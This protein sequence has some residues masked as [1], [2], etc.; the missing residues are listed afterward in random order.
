LT[1]QDLAER[2]ATSQSAISAIESGEVDPSFERLQKLLYLTGH[3]LS[4]ELRPLPVL[5]DG[6]LLAD[7]WRMF[8]EE[9]ISASIE[10]SRYTQSVRS[11]GQRALD[12]QFD[13]EL[14]ELEQL[15]GL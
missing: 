11:A 2:A 12:E 3:E 15:A 14:V 4:A 10:L 5:V 7:S 6:G 9:R 1:Q 8:P 13:R